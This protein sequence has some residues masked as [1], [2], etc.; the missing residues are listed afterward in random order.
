[1]KPSARPLFRALLALVLLYSSPA[2]ATEP[3]LARLS[4]WVPSARMAEFEKEY[5]TALV[6]LLEKHDLR[7]SSQP[8]RATPDSIFTRL[9]EFSSVAEFAERTG[10]LGEDSAYIAQLQRL[11]RRF[12]AARSDSTLVMY[13]E[14]YQQ[15]AGSG[16]PLQAGRE[17]GH[18]RTYDAS[19]GLNNVTVYHLLED[20]NGNLWVGTVGG[21][22]SRYDGSNFQN[23][24]RENGLAG[25]WIGGML[26]DRNG[27]LWI[28]TNIGV[29][30]Y[31]G[32]NFRNF[33]VEDGLAGN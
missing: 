22:I 27:N 10:A 18:W 26:E 8:G 29:S 1:M 9:F 3:I 30:R 7:E 32:S 6:P 12:G 20:R 4:F 23:F 5:A 14:L 16:Q 31:D 2:V 25:N 21:G 11:G 13:F 15:P 17:R 33:T 19:N 24:T 28:R